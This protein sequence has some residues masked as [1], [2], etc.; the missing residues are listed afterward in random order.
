MEDVSKFFFIPDLELRFE[1]FLTF[2]ETDESW[3]PCSP[4]LHSTRF[5]CGYEIRDDLAK[6]FQR[7][8]VCS[9]GRLSYS[10][11]RQTGQ[12]S[13][14]EQGRMVA[15]TS[16]LLEMMFSTRMNLSNLKAI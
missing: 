13:E 11:L 10:R 14:P 4:V 8:M 3:S 9:S 5:P 15:S 1:Q 16:R 2:V 6:K 7:E 12:W